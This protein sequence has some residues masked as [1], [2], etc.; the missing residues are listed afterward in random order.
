MAKMGRPSLYTDE[1][2]SLVETYIATYADLD[3][4]IPSVEGLSLFLNVS[5]DTIYEWAKDKKKSDFSDTLDKLKVLQQKILIKNG[6][7]STFNSTITKLMLGTHGIT[8]KTNTDITSGGKR[9]K[10][11]WTV[12]P[13]TTVKSG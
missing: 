11:E 6:L 12:N 3:D 13:V 4:I 5:R 8:E 9:I 7:N 2:P 1:M 10:N